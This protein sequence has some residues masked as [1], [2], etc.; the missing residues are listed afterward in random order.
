MPLLGAA[1]L[2]GPVAGLLLGLVS[3]AA[4]GSIGG[5]GLEQVGPQPGAVAFVAMLMVT[6][7]AV[8]ATAATKIALRVRQVTP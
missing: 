4:S 8:L 5:G 2:A 7:G 1:A 6:I 3:I